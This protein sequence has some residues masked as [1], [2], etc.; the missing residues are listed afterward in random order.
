MLYEN[1]QAW[2]EEARQNGLDKGRREGQANML[3]GL[4]EEDFG[5][6]DEQTRSLIYELDEGNLRACFKRLKSAQSLSDVIKM[7]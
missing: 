3:I 6:I 4:L 1:I 5:S 7:L 2:Y